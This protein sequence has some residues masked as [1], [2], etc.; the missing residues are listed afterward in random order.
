MRHQRASDSDLQVHPAVNHLVREAYATVRELVENPASEEVGRMLGDIRQ[1]FDGAAAIFGNAMFEVEEGRHGAQSMAVA[2]RNEHSTQLSAAREEFARQI[3]EASRRLAE[4]RSESERDLAEARREFERDLAQARSECRNLVDEANCNMGRAEDTV[5]YLARRY[6]LGNRSAPR[7]RFRGYWR[8]RPKER[9]ELT[10]IRNSLF[11]DAD[12]YLNSNPD[13]GASGMDAALHY[14]LHGAR[15][16]RDPSPYFSTHQYLITFPD[17]AES[18]WNAL[19]HYEIY[20]RREMR[21]IP[22]SLL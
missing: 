5:A 3:S 19:A 15:E 9:K 13:V 21:K 1:P 22:V 14:L 20:G 2:L 4:V 7:T 18:G 16:G 8:A 11:F 12:F 10:A 17:V 6:E